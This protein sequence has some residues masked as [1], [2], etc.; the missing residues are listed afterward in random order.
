MRLV[1]TGELR[2]QDSEQE[3][4]TQSR[5]TYLRRHRREKLWRKAM[6][7]RQEEATNSTHLNVRRAS[8][9]NIRRSCNLRIHSEHTLVSRGKINAYRRGWYVGLVIRLSGH[10]AIEGEEVIELALLFDL[11]DLLLRRRFLLGHVPEV[12][13]GVGALHHDLSISA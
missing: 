9:R 10:H 11:V 8:H 13:L 3:P 6:R 1:G 2:L 5:A 7:V 12:A 4:P